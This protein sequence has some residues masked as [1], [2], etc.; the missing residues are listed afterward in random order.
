MTK[1]KTVAVCLVTWPRYRH[2]QEGLVECVK[3]LRD[4]LTASRHDLIMVAS[5]ESQFVSGTSRDWLNR[6]CES[7]DINL[8]WRPQPANLGANMNSA[9]AAGAEADYQLLVQDDMYLQRDWD[10]SEDCDFL[11]AYPD[12]ALVRQD[13]YYTTLLGPVGGWL[14]YREADRH[15]RYFYCDE[16]HLRRTGQLLAYPEVGQHGSASLGLKDFL[17]ASDWRIACHGPFFKHGG[18]ESS[19]PE[20]WHEGYTCD[21]A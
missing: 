12:F 7:L 21:D 15:G 4:H 10:V 14:D 9:L 16:P 1:T 6:F 11:D 8:V 5:S 19:M 13:W 2:R 20:R 17:V 3:R 18:V